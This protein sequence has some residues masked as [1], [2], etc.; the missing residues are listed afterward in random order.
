MSTETTTKT[1]KTI[2]Q[3]DTYNQADDY[4]NNIMSD[5]ELVK[6]KRGKD[7]YRVKIWNPPVIKEETKK[8]KNKFKKGD[9]NNRRR[10]NDNKKIR[11]GSEQQ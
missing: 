7:T 10:K 1:W 3:F 8:V 6:V 2:A 5:H 9:N 11:N 4:R